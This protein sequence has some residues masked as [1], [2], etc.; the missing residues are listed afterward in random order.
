MKMR[1]GVLDMEPTMTIAVKE[2]LTAFIAVFNRQCLSKGF[3]YLFHNNLDSAPDFNESVI[4]GLKYGALS[5]NGIGAEIKPFLKLAMEQGFLSPDDCEGNPFAL[6]ALDIYSQ[7]HAE[8]QRGGQETASNWAFEYAMLMLTDP[9]VVADE[10]LLAN[11]IDEEMAREIYAEGEEGA[12][13][14]GDE[15]ENSE[16]SD[17]DEC[18]CEFC[19]E[20]R[21]FDNVD[22]TTIS[23]EDPMDAWVINSLG[24]ALLKHMNF[25]A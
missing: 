3:L 9:N 21:S 15:S 19:N 18:D 20:M 5:S 10:A 8:F 1:T 25:S 14:T 22:L 17:I 13:G 11:D 4:R 12:P 6:K 7:V 24:A 23:P 2:L 16:N